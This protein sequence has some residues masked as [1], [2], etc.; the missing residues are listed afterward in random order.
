VL[1][2]QVTQIGGRRVGS[3]NGQ[4]HT[5]LLPT[6]RQIKTIFQNGRWCFLT[7]GATEVMRM[8]GN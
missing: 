2:Q 7:G 1:V 5:P 3:S 4:Q 8:R 6:S